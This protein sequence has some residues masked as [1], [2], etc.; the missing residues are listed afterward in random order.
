MRKREEGREDER[1]CERREEGARERGGCVK[2][3]RG[4]GG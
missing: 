3:R 1:E 4:E 2:E